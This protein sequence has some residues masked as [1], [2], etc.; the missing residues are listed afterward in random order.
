MYQLGYVHRGLLAINF[1]LCFEKKS[2]TAQV[3]YPIVC[4]IKCIKFAQ[5]YLEGEI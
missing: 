1:H 2:V 4:T 5:M 3:F